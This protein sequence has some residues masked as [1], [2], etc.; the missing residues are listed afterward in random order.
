MYVSFMYDNEIHILTVI[1]QGN[2]ILKKFNSP[3]W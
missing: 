1:P 2:N 3:A